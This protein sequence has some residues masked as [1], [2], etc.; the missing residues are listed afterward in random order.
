MNEKIIDFMRHG[1][2]VGGRAFRGHRIDDPLSEQGWQ[3]MWDALPAE[4]PWQHIVTSP[5]VR[6]RAF[7]AALAG[8]R[9]LP[10]TV[11]EDFR[12]V[13]FGDWEGRTPDEI[14]ADNI[15][16]YTAFYRD[17]VNSRPAGA[18]GLDDFSDRV[19][20]AYERLILD[21]SAESILVVA[22]AGVMRAIITYVL[23]A[24]L[25]SMYRIKIENAGFVRVR[26]NSYGSKLE[27][28]NSQMAKQISS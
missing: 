20:R 9:N 17:P 24:P 19:S 23:G 21:T 6:C 28:F 13:G 26:V 5:L 1:E 25:V 4:M 18:E 2:P 15:E 27:L 12:E 10:L 8:K 11:E 22:H 7:A 14:K 3:Q 16:A